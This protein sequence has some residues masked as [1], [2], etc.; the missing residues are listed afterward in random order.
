[1][2]RRPITVIRLGHAPNCSSLGNVLDVL[3]WT[4]AAVAA[5]WVAAERLSQQTPVLARIAGWGDRD[6]PVVVTFDAAKKP[7][8]TLIERSALPEGPEAQALL[9]ARPR[10]AA[11]SHSGNAA[12]VMVKVEL[13]P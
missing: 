13:A 8:L 7:S 10:D 2:P 1:M 5:L 12:I 11:P 9:A 4:Q 3:V 6:L